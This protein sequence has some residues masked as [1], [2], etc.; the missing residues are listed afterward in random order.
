M[1]HN[2]LPGPTTVQSL[3]NIYNKIKND[4]SNIN[5]LTLQ[6]SLD[7]KKTEALQLEKFLKQLTSNE[8]NNGYPSEFIN[9][10]REALGKNANQIFTAKT[11]KQFEVEVQSVIDST[12]QAAQN[13]S[14]VTNLSNGIGNLGEEYVDITS[15]D[16]L[17]REIIKESYERTGAWI[18]QH[19]Y[20]NAPS[21]TSI[22]TSV[23]GKIDNSGLGYTYTVQPIIP[24][25]VKYLLRLLSQATFTTK[26]YSDSRVKLGGYGANFYRAFMSTANYAKIQFPD[27]VYWRMINC[28]TKHNSDDVKKLV[29]RIRLIYELTGIGQHYINDSI[30]ELLVNSTG[31]K[32]LIYR[33]NK[34]GDLRVISTAE[35]LNHYLSDEFIDKKI[36]QYDY[37]T[38][39]YGQ[40]KADIDI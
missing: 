19:F 36:A 26:N 6:S 2:S 10:I 15:V 13:S 38:L 11:G 35:L 18:K 1:G 22:Y 23:Q 34:T 21:E 39:I 16:N 28:L 40:I 29:Y 30:N 20:K 24:P 9:E 32:Y 12:F 5:Q 27:T 25:S 33:N 37:Q 31:A 8:I 3:Q 14:Y 7:Y 17:G 4:I